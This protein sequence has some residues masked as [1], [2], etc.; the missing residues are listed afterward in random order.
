MHFD[1]SSSVV[2]SPIVASCA[3]AWTHAASLIGIEDCH[4][5]TIQ[6]CNSHT[7]ALPSAFVDLAYPASSLAACLDCP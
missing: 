5:P 4:D 3:L 7:Q 2:A 6:D 1:L